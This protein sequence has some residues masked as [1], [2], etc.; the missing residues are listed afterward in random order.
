MNKILKWFTNDKDA[1]PKKTIY[2]WQD[3]AN[4]PTKETSCLV[5]RKNNDVLGMVHFDLF[6]PGIG[7]MQIAGH[8]VGEVVL[9]MEE[10][11]NPEYNRK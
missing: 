6:C 3:V 10:P 8:H 5:I 11:P 2:V 1:V 4:L 9:W 7:W